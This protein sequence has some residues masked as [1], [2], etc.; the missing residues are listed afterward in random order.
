MALLVPI[1][2]GTG[3]RGVLLTGLCH[4]YTPRH[5]TSTPRLVCLLAGAAAG[6]LYLWRAV[7]RA[8]GDGDEMD[9]PAGVWKRELGT[10]ALG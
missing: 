6:R 2:V 10:P 4:R 8:L 5:C 3:Y 9:E 1:K 7:E